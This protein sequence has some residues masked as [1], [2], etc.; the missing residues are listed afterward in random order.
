LGLFTDG[1]QEGN[2]ATQPSRAL[3]SSTGTEGVVFVVAEG[4]KQQITVK[5][6]AEDWEWWPSV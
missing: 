1:D 2:L 4:A 3:G 6:R 5:Q